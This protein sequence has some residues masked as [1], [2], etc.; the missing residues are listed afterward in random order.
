MGGEIAV[1]EAEPVRLDAVGGKFL[2]RVPGLVAMAPSPFGVDTTAEGVH[3]GVEVRADANPEHPRVIA[4][5]DHRC[6]L[7]FGIGCG[8]GQLP[9]K[10]A[11][12]EQSLHAQQESGPSD[13]ADEN[14]HLHTDRH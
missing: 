1:A 14:G 10:L 8:S 12:P 13:S 5:I 7:V 11:Q 2:F 9:G 4:D 6:Q 3:T